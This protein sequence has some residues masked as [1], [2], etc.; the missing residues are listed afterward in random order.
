MLQPIDHV[1]HADTPHFSN[2]LRTQGRTRLC[3][4]EPS[5]G[6]HRLATPDEQSV[7]I[8]VVLSQEDSHTVVF[9]SFGVQH[10]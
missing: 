5:P 8:A 3:I 1:C 6:V 10:V 4:L 2:R 9:K 7:E